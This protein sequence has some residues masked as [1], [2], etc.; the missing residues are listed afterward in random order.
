ME[1]RQAIIFAKLKKRIEMNK[2]WPERTS[3]VGLGIW[4]NAYICSFYLYE[5]YTLFV[6]Q[7]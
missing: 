6:L 2:N 7:Y 1:L 3:F 5:I 4:L